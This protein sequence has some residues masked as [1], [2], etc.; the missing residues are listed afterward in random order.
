[1]VRALIGSLL[2]AV[3]GV[4]CATTP[5]PPPEELLGPAELSRTGGCSDAFFYATSAEDTVALIVHW[6]DAASRAQAEGE[7]SEQ[8][9]LPH[10]DVRVTLQF[11]RFLSDGFCTDVVMPDRPQLLAEVPA[12][13]GEV[14]TRIVAEPGAEPFFPLAKAHLVLRDVVFEVPL[15]DGVETWRIESLELDDIEV[16]WFPG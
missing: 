2:L 3:A 11:G 5:G 13:S 1:L 10:A 15:T 8:V 6:P 4:A 9:A 14:E 7:W 12:S 16:G